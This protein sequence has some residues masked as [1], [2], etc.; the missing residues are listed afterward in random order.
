MSISKR[1][2]GIAIYYDGNYI[3]RVSKYYATNNIV[4]Y[5][6]NIGVLHNY[7]LHRAEVL[8]SETLSD[9]YVASSKSF[10][11]R[12]YTNDIAGRKNQLY[13]ERSNE[14]TLL[15]LG[16]QPIYHLSSGSSQ[17]DDATVANTLSLDMLYLTLENDISMAIIVAG[18]GCYIP[19]ASRL[20]SMGMDVMVVGWNIIHNDTPELECSDK[21]FEVAN[22]TEIISDILD[23][24][25]EVLDG[26]L[27]E[28]ELP[29][30]VVVAE[31][32]PFT[33]PSKEEAIEVELGDWG[34]GEIVTLNPNFGFIN[35]PNNNLYFHAS[36]YN[37]DF[38]EL[39]VGEG[40]E[41]VLEH[42]QDGS[43]VAKNVSILSSNLHHF[44]EEEE[45]YSLSEEFI[46][47]ES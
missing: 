38:S 47:W 34:V 20:K 10:R 12:K 35:Y 25:P 36:D 13:W 43:L 7:I 14:D 31:E 40:V 22:F 19:L 2:R 17:C 9:V 37:G 33:P 16:I 6:F 4:S 27:K 29:K 24:T 23:D 46:D 11:S 41:F 26:M 21:L 39:K 42:N 8:A 32:Q 3:N 15:E 30:P 28:V 44:D 45:S 5:R 1:K 18:S